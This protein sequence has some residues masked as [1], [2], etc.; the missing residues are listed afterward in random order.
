LS[1]SPPKLLRESLGGNLRPSD[2]RRYLIES[3]VGAMHADGSVDER[4]TRA[5]RRLLAEHDLF[6]ALSPQVA[7]MLIDLA[8]DSIAFAG[9]VEHRITSIARALYT[10]THRLAAYAMAC[11]VCAADQEVAESELGYLASLRRS[12][13]VTEREHKEILAAAR[14]NH[15]MMLLERKAEE[16][17][18]LV[19]RIADC[20]ALRK[21]SVGPLETDECNRIRMVMRT[22]P[23]IDVLPEVIDEEV[24]RARRTAPSWSHIGEE[25]VRLAASV[26]EE[27]DRFWLVVHVLVSE[28]ARGCTSWHEVQFITALQRVFGLDDD[29]MDAAEVTARLHEAAA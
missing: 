16:A 20:L 7:E 11:E 8:S 15:A 9:G 13:T 1:S 27:A 3:M 14:Q 26:P 23:D 2:P 18:E 21:L 10:R 24:E 19:P 22:I 12:L 28:L 4:E 17:R 25:L 5:L 29:Q 6:A